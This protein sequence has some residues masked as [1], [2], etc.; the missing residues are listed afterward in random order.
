MSM[1]S[2]LTANMSL[3]KMQVMQSVNTRTQGQIGVLKAE[4]QLEGG[5]EKK[6]EKVKQLTQKSSDLMGSMMEELKNAN[7]QLASPEEDRP[8]NTDQ[9]E[10][11]HK[12][13]NTG[14]EENEE[15]E[16]KIQASSAVSYDAEGKKT[17]KTETKPGEK[18]DVKA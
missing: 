15:G 8:S 10:I 11:S 9:V 17:E 3:A 5:N 18:M 7:A 14:K 12:T 6:E 2:L 16:G 4:I 13:E 1:Q